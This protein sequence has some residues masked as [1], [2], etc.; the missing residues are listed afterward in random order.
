MDKEGFMAASYHL[1]F[2]NLF[3]EV[4]DNVFFNF[5]NVSIKIFAT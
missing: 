3:L 1:T 4:F 5:E 2:S